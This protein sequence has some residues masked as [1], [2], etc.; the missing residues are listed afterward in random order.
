MSRVF[1]FS[2]FILV[3][4]VVLGGCGGSAKKVD[5]AAD[6]A[7]ANAA[8]LTAADMSGYTAT[9]YQ[10]SGDIPD[11]VKKNFAKCLNVKATIFDDTPGAQKV[12]SPDFKQGS[13]TVSGTVEI[14][15]KRSDIDNGWNTLSKSGFERCMQQLFNAVFTS[16]M[17]SGA[18]VGD[19][20]VTKFDVGVGSRSLGVEAKTSISYRGR[21]FV[22]YID[23]LM[24][25]RDRA[26]I[27]VDTVQLN[28]P[29]TRATEIALARTVYDRIGTK[30]S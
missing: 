25:A 17:P 5:P 2:A 11:P 28:H 8:S 22:S 10:K 6:L 23:F 12:H 13:A 30:T 1:G 29:F 24:V 3:P 9:P 19:T 16:A 26:G 21:S 4:L 15:P 7:L 20:T 14:D 18:T 27:E